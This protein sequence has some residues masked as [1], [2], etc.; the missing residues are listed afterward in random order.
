MA[1]AGRSTLGL[2]P[3]V[4][5]LVDD[6]AGHSTQTKGLLARLGLPSEIKPLS[7]NGFAALPNLFNRS[8]TAHLTASSRALLKAPYPRMVIACGRRMAPILRAIKRRSPNTITVYLMWPDSLYGID[9]AVVP[10]H[11]NPPQAAN[12]LVTHAPL[13]AITPEGLAAAERTM[14]SRFA[15]LPRPWIGV[16]IGGSVRGMVFSKDDWRR[17]ITHA[18]A[19]APQGSLLI[20]TSRRTP[21]EIE[22][23]LEEELSGACYFHRYS[24]GGY[25]PYMSF[26]ACSDAMCVSGD[27]MS[28]CAEAT[29]TGKPVFIF[30]PE[31]AHSK[32]HMAQHEHLFEKNLARPLDE[33]ARIS[34]RPDQHVS[35]IYRVV[36]AVRRRFPQVFEGL[37]APVV[38]PA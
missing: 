23:M 9:L 16:S 36:R 13:T 1:G 8:G 27:S 31:H 28:M 22:Q 2:A 12:V 30:T 20:T 14:I 11:D 35:D 6:R 38:E 18:R 37:I 4:W 33:K 26:L 7:Y 34:W 17:M 25:N 15:H 19:L 32:K 29:V 3:T 5:G 24:A 21:M 10:A